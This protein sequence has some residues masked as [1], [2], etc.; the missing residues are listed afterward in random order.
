[1][2]FCVGLIVTVLLLR[3]HFI[4]SPWFLLFCLSIIHHVQLFTGINQQ[5]PR[6]RKYSTAIVGEFLF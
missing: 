5:V 3:G 4:V 6:Q 2:C 1:M